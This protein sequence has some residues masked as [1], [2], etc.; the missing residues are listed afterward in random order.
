MTTTGLFGLLVLGQTAHSVEEYTGRLWESFPPAALLSGLVSDDRAFG[1]LIINV[2]LNAFGGAAWLW[3]VAW[4]RAVAPAVAWFFVVVEIVNGVGHPLW[5]LRQA[6][7]TPGV[8]TAPIL[9]ACALLLAREL[10][11]SG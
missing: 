10:R 7:Y 3:A 6:A 4:Q 2:A 9:L 8:A 1:F 5:S 11:R